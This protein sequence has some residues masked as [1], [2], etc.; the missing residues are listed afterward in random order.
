MKCANCGL[1][2]AEC[3]F[4]VRSKIDGS[5]IQEA[6]SLCGDCLNQRITSLM[7]E[8]ES[9]E[10]AHCGHTIRPKSADAMKDKDGRVF[11]DVICACDFYHDTM[12]LAYIKWDK[13]ETE[14]NNNDNDT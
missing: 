4:E 7:G 6:V 11:C 8:K 3:E 5:A 14:E 12:R 13:A 9:L 10:C 1:A 2:E